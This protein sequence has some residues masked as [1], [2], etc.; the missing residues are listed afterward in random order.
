MM[1]VLS[2]VA[3]LMTPG[4]TNS[5]VAL[6]GYRLGVTRGGRLLLAEVWGYLLVVVPLALAGNGLEANF[7]LVTNL[8]KL[9]A[10]IWVA[11]LAIKMWRTRV[12][13]PGDGAPTMRDVF[14]TTLLN[15]KSLI[16][17]L[18]LFPSASAVAPF[19]TLVAIF[20]ATVVA[21]GGVWLSIGAAGRMGR[22]PSAGVGMQAQ[23]LTRAAAV[24]LGLLSTGLAASSFQ[25]W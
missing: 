10:A 9:A 1:F 19:A 18:V 17:G 3:L 22:R 24:W 7:P 21:V 25:H 16:I 2:L 8:L 12:H 4:P 6:A 13:G 23:W 11:R 5:L 20:A 14:V 15:P